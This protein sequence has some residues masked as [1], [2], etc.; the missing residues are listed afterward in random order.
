MECYEKCYPGVYGSSISVLI[1]T[2]SLPRVTCM[3][4]KKTEKGVRGCKKRGQSGTD[5]EI[6]R[7]IDKWLWFVKTSQQAGRLSRAFSWM[8]V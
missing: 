3:E 1:C 7:D 4:S 6:S 2:E 5:M 8:P